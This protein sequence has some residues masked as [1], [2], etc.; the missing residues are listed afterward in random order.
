VNAVFV[1]SGDLREERVQTATP[2]AASSG[3]SFDTHFASEKHT[4]QPW[5]TLQIETLV[6]K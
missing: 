2:S 5:H 6:S 3:T 4:Q 1:S